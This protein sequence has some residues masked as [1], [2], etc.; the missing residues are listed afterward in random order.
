MRLLVVSQYFWPENFRIN[1]LVG[2]LVSRGHQV[3]VL[4]GLPN[5]PEGKV[6]QEYREDPQRFLN[7][8][9][10]KIIRVPMTARG[11]GSL[12]LMLNYLSF[13]VSASVLGFWKLR[14]R[15]FDSIFAYQASPVTVGLPAVVM[16][17]IKSAP[18]AFWVLDLW[19]ET[20]Q[21]VGVVRRPIFLRA[22]GKL[23]S[24]I[25]KRS[26]LILVQSKRFIPQVQK[27]AGN[28]IRVEYFPSWAE[29]FF[30]SKD[31][32]YADEVPPK[33]GSFNV[34]FAGNIGDAQ[35]FPAILA[36]AESLKSHSHI[37]WL[38]VG[39]GRLARW[40]ADEI[41]RR[42]LHDCVLMLGRYPVERMPAFFKHANALLVS[43]K[44]EPI[45]SMTIPGKLQ[46]YLAAGIPVLAMLN[47]EGA[48]VV[49]D[50]QSGLTCAAGD[51]AGLA[52]AVLRL[53]EM[54]NKQLGAMGRNGLKVS[55]S[56]F[57]RKTLMNQLEEWLKN[58]KAE[59]RSP[60][61]PTKTNESP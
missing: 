13:A 43:L 32:G 21:A 58:L 14:G 5:Y 23:V 26:D 29:P 24:Y 15:Q 31:D 9:G 60:Q 27:Y 61:L 16:R 49:R 1:D 52:A 54:T 10:A 28:S 55:A 50:S 8:E 33:T 7:Y 17:A 36:A 2:E 18:L 38:I 12:R 3:T 19:P 41:K 56:E 37:R 48:K 53:S 11:Q 44:D 34:L 22:V 45:F 35:D 30:G 40:V 4:T 42:N 20:L 6:F 47:G 39:D 59:K 51:H 25:Y 46:S 57:D